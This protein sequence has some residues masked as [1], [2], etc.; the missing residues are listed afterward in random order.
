VLHGFLL[1]GVEIMNLDLKDAVA[2]LK[3][4]NREYNIAL[5]SWRY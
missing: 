3:N 1:T 4:Y 5:V 2:V